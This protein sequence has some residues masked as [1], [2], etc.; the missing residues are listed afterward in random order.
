MGDGRQA[1]DDRVIRGG[2]WNNDA[3]NVRA[4]SR[5]GNHPDDR[6]DNLGFRCARAH[7]RTDVW[8]GTDRRPRRSAR[9]AKTGAG[10]VLVARV[11]PGRR[12]A[13]F[14]YMLS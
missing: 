14:F 8:I 10:G 9:Y 12:L 1:G 11:E 2:S 5:N 3:R 7:D 6:N 4:A 13:A